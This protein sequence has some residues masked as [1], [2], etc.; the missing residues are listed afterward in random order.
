MGVDA[1]TRS[2]HRCD[3]H[4]RNAALIAFLIGKLLKMSRVLA[5]VLL[6][7]L[8][9]QSL[10][11]AAAPYCDLTSH[12]HASGKEQAHHHAPASAA[13]A[14]V[15]SVEAADNAAPGHSHAQLHDACCAHGLAAL[16]TSQV[17]PNTVSTGVVFDMPR[18]VC[19]LTS[20]VS[21][22]PERPQWHVPRTPV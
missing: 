3:W 14:D 4:I 10:R 11:V 12:E 5:L 9:L 15:D 7:L 22:R 8:S 1:D 20:P 17:R 21:M 13:D 18:S 2:N 6:V 19:V 16:L